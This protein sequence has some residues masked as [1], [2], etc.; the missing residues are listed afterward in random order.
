MHW[1]LTW[2]VFKSL[3]VE[4]NIFSDINWTLTWYV[5]KYDKWGLCKEG[6]RIEL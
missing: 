3:T 6:Y 2:Y 4:N 1:T 5:F